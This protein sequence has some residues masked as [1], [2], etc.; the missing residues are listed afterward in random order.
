MLNQ[1]IINIQISA[2]FLINLFFKQYIV[3]NFNNLQTTQYPPLLSCVT[4]QELIDFVM[5]DYIG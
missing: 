1:W 4:L 3:I 5:I 2:F